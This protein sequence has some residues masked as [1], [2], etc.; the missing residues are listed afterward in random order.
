MENNKSL[1]HLGALIAVEGIDGS[2]K[3]TLVKSIEKDLKEEGF[4]TIR[5]TTREEGKEKIFDEINKIYQLDPSSQ[6]YMFFFQMLHALK[7]K[8]T[9]K[10]LAEGVNVIADRWDLSFFAYH[11]NFG[12]LS[13]ETNYLREEISRIAFKDL[14]PDLGIYLDVSVKKAMDRRLWRGEM[15]NDLKREKNFYEVVTKSYKSL[16][17]KN[18]WKI[19]DANNGFED[20]KKTVWSLVLEAVKQKNPAL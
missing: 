4:E 14:R 18:G 7:V 5:I 12:F 11:E 13:K 1:N 10:A 9:M 3:S 16:S 2:G 17:S 6:A 19:V 20:V 15:I 8:K